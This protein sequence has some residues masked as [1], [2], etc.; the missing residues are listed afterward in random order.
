MI[1][2]WAQRFA[3]AIERPA[4]AYGLVVAAVAAAVGVRLLAGLLIA[5]P[6]AFMAFFPAVLFA[7]LVAGGRGGLL[8]VALSVVAVVAF[9]LPHIPAHRLWATQHVQVAMF[10]ATCVIMVAMARALRAGILH[11]VTAEE[12]FRAA[13]ERALDAFVIV[14]A[15]RTGDRIVDFVWSYANPAA[16]RMAPAGIDGLTG[17]RVLSVFPGDA[18]QLIFERYLDLHARGGPDLLETQRVIDGQE[19]WVRT[20]GVRVRNSLAVTFRDITEERQAAEAVRAAEAE[21][22]RSRDE[23]EHIANATPVMI[24]MSDASTRC[25]WVNQRW[26]DFSGREMAAELGVGWMDRLHPDDKAT[27]RANYG[28]SIAHSDPFHAQYRLLRHDGEYRWIEGFAAP[29]LDEQ[30]ELIGYISSAVDINDRKSAEEALRVGAGRMRALMETLPQMM[31]ANRADGYCDYLSTQWLAYTGVRAEDHL[32]FGWLDA[33]HP[34]DRDDCRRAWEQAVAGTLPFDVEYRIRRHDGVWRWFQGRAAAVRDGEGRATRW[35]GSSSDI[36]EIVEARRDLETRVAERTRELQES[37][38]ERERAEAALAQA[39]RLETVGRLTGGVAHDFN[40]LL[41]VVIGG[42]DMMLR[43]PNDAARVTRLGEAA[44]AAGRRGERLTRQLL[45]FSRRQELKLDVM[46]VGALIA[47]V[48]PLV[49]RAAGE[50]IELSVRTDPATGASRLDGAQFEAALLNLVVNAADAIGA[51]AGRIEIAVDRTTLRDGE[52]GGA[53]A[54]DYV[55]VAVS[56]SGAGMSPEVLKRVFEPFFTTKEVG[57][58]TGLGLAQVYGFVTQCGG[59]VT[60]DSQV[61]QGA[62]VTLLLPAVEAPPTV[63]ATAEPQTFSAVSTE[64]AKVLLVEDDVAVRAVAEGLL[65]ELGCE[66][67]AEPDAPSAL[68]RLAEGGR[69]DVLISDIVMPGGMSGLDLAQAARQARPE[70]PILLTTGY[71]GEQWGAAAAAADWPILRKP[72]RAEQL[73]AALRKVLDWTSE[74]A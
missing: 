4:A 38:E 1:G 22:R 21:A 67:Q 24:W 11:G 51:G 54:G 37:L 29:R 33:I 73:G 64:G 14:D 40:N 8:A 32:G 3:T 16:D 27:W 70:L 43:T 12:R 50:A 36:T 35:F 6:P 63:I 44:L 55:R 68:R 13:Q 34:E 53:A 57:K 59:A 2:R 62:T 5:D 56:D 25:T 58:G 26:L 41:T 69:F 17:R 65:I 71:A 15:V 9:F 7:T 45:A 39:Q 31:W 52:V 20:S 72:F 66:V 42:L 48:E 30:G 23:F 10:A 19:R 46:D 74:T 18:G 47:Q 60:I 28:E 61:G 49:R